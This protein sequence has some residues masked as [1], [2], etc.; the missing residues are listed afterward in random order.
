MAGKIK[1]LIVDDS[2]LVQEVLTSILEAHPSFDVVGAAE[3]PFEARDLVK[4]FRPDV[5]TMDVEMPKM[6]GISFLRN[7]MRLNPLPVVMVSTL[8][9]AGSD[10][11]I[12][13]LEIGA[14]DFIQKPS[15]LT[16]NLDTFSSLLI[17]K[18]E[19][20]AHVSQLKLRAHQ[21]RLQ[22]EAKDAPAP[23]AKLSSSLGF[24]KRVI[25][26][27]GSTGGLEATRH[28]LTHTNFTGK[29]TILICLHLPGNFTRSYAQRLDQILPL[30]VKEAEHGEKLKQGH[31]YIAP[32]TVHL[33]AT[34]RGGVWY[35]NLLD[36]EP[37]S[38]HKPS[39]DVLFSS[40]ANQPKQ[41]SMGILLTGMGR[42]GAQGM[43]Q[44]HEAGSTTIAQ[45]EESSIVWGMPGQAVQMGG[46]SK[47]LHL[48]DIAAEIEAFR[49]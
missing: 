34:E 13:A 43:V 26:M 48:D 21:T 49:F 23:R 36:T 3:D 40:V 35:A 41:R 39:V 1:V 44:L 17:A 10:T 5:L 16:R 37:V 22:K 33:A 2:R 47:I 19:A 45:D 15:D 14:I 29:E 27:G 9:A 42:D 11:T 31:I 30:T 24:A 25:C 7:L 46:A 38:M 28:V 20:A 32:G 8:T 4:Q 12:N 18:V 6:D